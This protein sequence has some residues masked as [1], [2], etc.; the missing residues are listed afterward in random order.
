[1]LLDSQYLEDCFNGVPGANCGLPHNFITD[2]RYTA[3]L[4]LAFGTSEFAAYPLA[5]PST[6][7][8]NDDVADVLTQI[9]AEFQSSLSAS[10]EKIE[11]KFM[12]PTEYEYK[13]YYFM[14]DKEA[15]ERNMVILPAAYF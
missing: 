6:Y 9:V 3:G 12:P 1:M 4:T 10:Q 2:A 5:D 13:P 8:F 11:A 7:F 15:G 14:T